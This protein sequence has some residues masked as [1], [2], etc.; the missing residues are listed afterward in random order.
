MLD[1]LPQGA[2]WSLLGV[3]RHQLPVNL[4]SLAFGGHVRTGLEDNVY[5][6]R[7]ELATS[8]GQLV[9][10]VVRLAGEIGR[11]IATPADARALIDSREVDV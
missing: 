8:N 2:Y 7:G 6:R 10:R 3:G 4:F 1:R 9:A 5:Y 11:P